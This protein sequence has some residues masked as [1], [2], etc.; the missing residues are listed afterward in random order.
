M[1]TFAEALK[2]VCV[3][4]N[5]D[6][7]EERLRVQ[8]EFRDEVFNSEMAT[9]IAKRV[10]HGVSQLAGE[11][12]DSEEAKISLYLNGMIHGVTVGVEMER[13]EVF[14]KT[15]LWRRAWEK[16]KGVRF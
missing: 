11:D 5:E 8:S 16:F 3:C 6:Q 7:E 12:A 10:I 9:V 2:A 4:E 1:K 14:V 13:N 15:P